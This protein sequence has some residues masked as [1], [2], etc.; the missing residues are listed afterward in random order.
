[1]D[2]KNR[3]GLKLS[4]FL[5]LIFLAAVYFDLTKV[6]DKKIVWLEKHDGYALI[7][8]STGK[9]TSI[10]MFNFQ[11][12]QVKENNGNPNQDNLSINGEAT[13]YSRVLHNDIYNV[14]GRAEYKPIRV[15]LECSEFEYK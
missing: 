15:T 2:S 9:A 3:F 5:V 8:P 1:M 7:S 12:L 13:I 4:A 6:E 10:C 11:Y 14:D